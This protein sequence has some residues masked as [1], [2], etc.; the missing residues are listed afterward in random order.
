MGRW[1]SATRARI[2]ERL[3][4]VDEP[5]E[6]A[7]VLRGRALEEEAALVVV[8]PEAHDVAG[9][10]IDVEADGVGTEAPPVREA[11]R[12][13]DEVAEVDR[14]EHVPAARG[15]HASR[16]RNSTAMRLKRSGASHCT[17]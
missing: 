4:V 6:G 16:P 17:Q 8:E 7:D 2:V 11:R 12:A 1:A 15:G 3:V 5:A 14:S 13:D 10:L 9:E